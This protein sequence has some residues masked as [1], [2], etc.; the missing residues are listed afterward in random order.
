[1]RAAKEQWDQLASTLQHV[2]KKFKVGKRVMMENGQEGIQTSRGTTPAR[3]A[4]APAPA[5][6]QVSEDEDAQEGEG[7]KE[8]E[9][10]QSQDDNGDEEGL[11][12]MLD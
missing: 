9:E 5:A 12:N 4:S 10:E 6:A 1:M 11:E 2:P 7:D 3:K 8:D